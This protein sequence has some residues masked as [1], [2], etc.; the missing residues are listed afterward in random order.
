MTD[1]VVT[2]AGRAAIAALAG[3]DQVDITHVAIGDGGGDTDATRTALRNERLRAPAIG[4]GAADLIAVTGAFTPAAEW[5]VREVGL[6]GRVGA[7]QPFLFAYG[8][9]DTAATP[10]ATAVSGVDLIVGSTLLIDP[11][12]DSVSVTLSP[13][14]VTQSVTPAMRVFTASGTLTATSARYWLVAAFGGG[15]TA[16]LTGLGVSQKYGVAGASAS[17]TGTGV[18]IVAAGGAGGL[19]GSDGAAGGAGTVSGARAVGVGITGGGNRAG[20]RTRQSSAGGG[21]PGGPGGACYALV[22]PEAGEAYSITIGAAPTASQ[23][24]THAAP[25]QPVVV[26]IELLD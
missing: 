20:H 26:I 6:I 4:A 15:G 21:F 5:H 1:L 16:S 12:D 25:V 10:I 14:V 11:S 3:M 24:S 19:L 7:G 13:Q 23:P 2:D 9:V 18:S 8:A 22:T 17:I